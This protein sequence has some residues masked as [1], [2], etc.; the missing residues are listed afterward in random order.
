MQVFQSSKLKGDPDSKEAEDCT[1]IQLVTE[2]YFLA[3]SQR[4]L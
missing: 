3:R 4:Q 2:R 1:N